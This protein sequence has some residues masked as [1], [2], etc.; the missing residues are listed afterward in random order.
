MPKAFSSGSC[1]GFPTDTN[2]QNTQLF[3]GFLQKAESER[4]LIQDQINATNT[5]VV[6]DRCEWGHIWGALLVE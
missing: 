6:T 5:K 2:E 3:S 1:R 4:Q